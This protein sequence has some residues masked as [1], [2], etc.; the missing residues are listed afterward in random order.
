MPETEK[1][2]SPFVKNIA[3]HLKDAWLHVMSDA[4]LAT[5]GTAIP[6]D[7]AFEKM[8]RYVWAHADIDDDG[9]GDSY[10]HMRECVEKALDV[11][12]EGGNTLRDY[13]FGQGGF[14]KEMQFHLLEALK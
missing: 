6:T 1:A 3:G 2:A 10:A 14:V 9:F 8:A 5:G 4:P 7:K 12:D 11:R 13:T